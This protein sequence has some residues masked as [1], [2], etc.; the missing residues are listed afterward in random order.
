ME[1][2]NFKLYQNYQIDWKAYQD[3]EKNNPN[4]II[5]YY[6]SDYVKPGNLL[7]YIGDVENT[8][9]SYFVTKGTDYDVIKKQFINDNLDT[10]ITIYD[11]AVKLGLRKHKN[12]KE[13][14]GYKIVSLRQGP[15]E[16]VKPLLKDK[17]KDIINR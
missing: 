2:N 9:I 8:Y 1:T 6:V 5:R 13:I 12:R 17:L 7:I 4:P 14:K 10:K 16:F 15:L 3:Y 11:L